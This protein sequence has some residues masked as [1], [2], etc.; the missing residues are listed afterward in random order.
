M[1]KIS[2]I[3]IVVM[4]VMFINNVSAQELKFYIVNETGFDLS[5]IYVSPKEDDNWGDDILPEEL[6]A[7][8]MTVEV[9]IPDEYGEDCYFDLK[10]TDTA[11]GST[12]FRKID[13]CHLHGK[14]LFIHADG[15]GIIC[16]TETPC[17]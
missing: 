1:K 15:N 6:F 13:A 10:I 2:F 17:K 14:Y 4:C 8:D 12:E 5:D 7:K 9:T 11:G 3:G 16:P